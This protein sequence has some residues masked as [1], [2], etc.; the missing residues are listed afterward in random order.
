MEL[1]CLYDKNHA[2]LPV[3]ISALF[4]IT[5]AIFSVLQRLEA[6]KTHFPDSLS[7]QGSSFYWTNERLLDTIW[8]KGSHHCF[9]CG[10]QVSGPL[11]K[12]MRVL[13]EG[14]CMHLGGRIV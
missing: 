2:I 12:G 9:Y 7:L 11:N 5:F 4:R 6:R 1:H 13:V 10:R 8:K 3:G 14:R